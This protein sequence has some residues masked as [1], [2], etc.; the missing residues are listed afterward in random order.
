MIKSRQDLEAIK[1]RMEPVLHL[2]KAKHK[3]R[4]MFRYNETAKFAGIDTLVSDTLAKVYEDKH[5]AV[6]I[7]IYD[8]RVGDK[9]ILVVK[10]SNRAVRYNVKDFATV[11]EIL[12]HHLGQNEVLF[13]YIE[14]VGKEG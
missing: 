1:K 7:K 2:R 5:D 13:K 3:Y 10:E 11:I 6:V 9:V 8:E 14:T 4:L 12:N